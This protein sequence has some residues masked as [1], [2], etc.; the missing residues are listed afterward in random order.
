MGK[1]SVLLC[2]SS[3]LLRSTQRKYLEDNGYFV[4]EET[5]NGQNA[6]DCCRKLA[7][8]LVVAEME[9]PDMDGLELLSALKAEFPDIKAVF[10]GPQSRASEVKDIPFL[11]KPVREPDLI[12]AVKSQIGEPEPIDLDDLA[13]YSRAKRYMSRQ[14][15]LCSRLQKE[16]QARQKALAEKIKELAT[17]LPKQQGIFQKAAR[18]KLEDDL[19]ECQH[20]LEESKKKGREYEDKYNEAKENVKK[21][22][23]LKELH[24]ELDD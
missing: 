24:P 19:A 21:L 14:I 18:K 9:L 16:E 5:E 17:A 13:N 10:C 3:D 20:L 15:N 22:R 6:L 12:S 23:A 7:P 1:Q 11:P 8:T 2:N 4:C